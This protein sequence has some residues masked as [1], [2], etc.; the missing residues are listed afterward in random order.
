MRLTNLTQTDASPFLILPCPSAPSLASF[1]PPLKVAAGAAAALASDPQEL[2]HA[3]ELLHAADVSYLYAACCARLV[4]L[5]HCV[6]DCLHRSLTTAATA[7]PGSSGVLRL[8]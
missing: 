8:P 2:Q 1:A 7:G 3:A 5:N 6:Q 4:W